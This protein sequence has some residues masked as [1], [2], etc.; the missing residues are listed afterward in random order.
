MNKISKKIVSLVTMAAFALTLVPAAAFAEVGKVDDSSAAVSTV[1][2]NTAKVTINLGKTD[3]SESDNYIVW[4]TDAEDNVVAQ[5]GTTGVNYGAATGTDIQIQNWEGADG[6]AEN[7]VVLEKVDN[8]AQAA[9]V[10]VNATF[11]TPGKYTLHAAL[12]E[13]GAVSL[14]DAAVKELTVENATF[15][16]YGAAERAA[17]EYGVMKDGD[18]QKTASVNVNKTLTTAFEIN[19]ASGAYTNDELENVVIWAIDSRTDDPTSYLVVDGTAATAANDY[20]I[21]VTNVANPKTVDIQFTMAGE[22]TIYA[23]IANGNSVDDNLKLLGATK[24]TVNDT[25]EIDSLTLKDEAGNALPYDKES[26]TFTLDLTKDAVKGDFVFGGSDVYT[27]NGTAFDGKDEALNQELTFSTENTDIVEFVDADKTVNTGNTGTFKLEFSMQD[28]KNAVI[29]ITDSKTGDEYN[30]RIIATKTTAKDI[31][32]SKTGG[33]VIASTDDQFAANINRNLADAVQFVITDEKTDAVTGWDAIAGEPAAN[34]NDTDHEKYLRVMERADGSN[35]V[36]DDLELVNDGDHYTLKYVGATNDADKLVPGKYQVRVT[37]LSGDNATVT[38]TAA[39]FGKVVDMEIELEAWNGSDL[40][41]KPTDRGYT[42]DDEV[43]L[44]QIVVA[45]AT[46]VDGNGIKVAADGSTIDFGF[47]G[48]AVRDVNEAN[49]IF[50]TAYDTPANES[51]LGTTIKVTAFDRVNKQLIKKELTVVD[52]YNTYSLEFDPTEGPINEDNK[53]TVTVVDQDGEKA[54]ISNG[55]VKA[56]IADK[57]DADAK[58]SVKA[59]NFSNG[60]ATLTVY[61]DRETTADIVVMVK[62][63][64]AIY[65]A[66]LEYTFGTADPLA[67]RTVVMTIDSTEYVVNNNVITGDAAPY[68]DSNWRTM[69]PIRALAEAFDAEVIWNQDDSTVTIN[70]DGDTQIVMTVDEQTYTVNGA[71]ATM[72]TEPVNAG[73]RVYVP[74]RFAAEGLGF[75]VTPLYNADGLTASVVFQR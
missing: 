67:D 68:V 13:T 72:D 12:N 49:A 21:P 50:G 30:V 71:E 9:T 58:V 19:D 25:T 36:A 10:T 2:Y 31:D 23:G 1:S 69:V 11:A 42:V 63:G 41:Q 57:S 55:T 39:K 20:Q 64:S 8:T 33:Y 43:T 53:V 35:L 3:V 18:V 5:N 14:E 65:P 22:Y 15:D 62:A 26:N 61:S 48:K 17:S 29:T 44:G 27:I 47:D 75:S 56:Y 4:A 66:T 45:T 54:K 32:R 73:D 60:K 51:L 70:F 28:K 38:F 74:I 16:A 46:Y 52:S 6:Q 59:G 24:V 34:K 7:A 40:Q 37:L